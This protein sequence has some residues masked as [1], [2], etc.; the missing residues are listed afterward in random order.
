MSRARCPVRGSRAMGRP[1]VL[2]IIAGDPR[3][4]T[5][6]EPANPLRPHL[7]GRRPLARRLQA[8]R[9]RPRDPAF[10]VLRRPTVCW[11][12]PRPRC[13]PARA[14]RRGRALYLVVERAFQSTS[15]H[16]DKHGLARGADPQ[17]QAPARQRLRDTENVP[18]SEGRRLKLG[19]RCCPAPLTPGSTTTNPDRL[20]DPL[21]LPLLP[22]S[23]PPRL[24]A[25][26]DADLKRWDGPD[27]ADDRGLAG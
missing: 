22:S 18:L 15:P 9:I 4:T 21:Q 5:P 20:R 27:Q 7:V 10:T 25:E 6:S 26:I 1:I 14:T 17:G 23:E 8:V 19:A 16:V 24:L 11:R 3:P 12:R 2:P 13:S